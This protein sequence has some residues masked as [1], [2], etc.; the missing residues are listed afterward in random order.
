MNRK[1]SCTKLKYDA[2]KIH[3]FTN[4]VVHGLNVLQYHE[5]CLYVQGYYLVKFQNHLD[6]N[7]TRGLRS[8]PPEK[9]K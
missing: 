7:K 4:R 2:K 1:S 9:Q 3:L 5:N 8:W 6:E